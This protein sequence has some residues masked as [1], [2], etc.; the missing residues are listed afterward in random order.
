MFVHNRWPNATMKQSPHKV[1]LGYQPSTTQGLSKI[2][3]NKAAESRQQLIKEHRAAAVQ[4]LNQVAK[5]KPPTQYKVGD[6]VWLEAKHLTLS[7]TSAKLVPKRHGPFQIVKDISPVAYQLELPKA[8]T[9]H[10][11]FHSSILT[12]YKE[13]DEHGDN[14]Q[15]PPPEMIDN[16]EEYEV[17]LI[18]SHRYH[19]KRRQ[20]Q[21]LIQ[22]KGYSAADDTWEPADQVHAP[23]LVRKYHQKHPLKD[24]KS[25]QSKTRAKYLITCHITTEPC[26]PH[27][28]H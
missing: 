11:I 16:A 20:L 3:N 1:L 17:E 8:W 5:T 13:T 27:P 7:Y 21:Y 9:I 18:I 15:C 23:D 6:Q 24:D 14:Y 26:R 12:P 10:D 22:W 4:A 2:T 25:M 28:P 19:G